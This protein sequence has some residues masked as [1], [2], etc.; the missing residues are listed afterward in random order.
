MKE[1]VI[2]SRGRENTTMKIVVRTIF[3]TEDERTPILD[4]G[5]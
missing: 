4:P 5:T 2:A 3:Q 1:D